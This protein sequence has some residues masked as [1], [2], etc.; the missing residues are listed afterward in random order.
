[1]KRKS[2]I[3]FFSLIFMSF[4]LVGCGQKNQDIALCDSLEPKLDNY[5]KGEMTYEVFLNQ[6]EKDYNNYCID[7]E[8]TLCTGISL[9][10]KL[11]SSYDNAHTTATTYRIDCAN[12]RK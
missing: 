9:Q 6:L 4:L 3:Y 7:R 12:A 2:L 11:K 5:E 1:M 8:S 10:L